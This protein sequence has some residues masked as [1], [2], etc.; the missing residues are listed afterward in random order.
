MK[1]VGIIP[2]RME[3]KRLPGKP[4][5]KIGGKSMIQR[6]YEASIKCN[7]LNDVYVASDNDEIINHV[8]LFGN[9]IKTSSKPINGTE[10]VYEAYLK[11]QKKYDFI[12]NIQGDEPFINSN[13]INDL[14]Q[15]CNKKNEICTLIKEHKY[16]DELNKNSVIKVVMNKDY[17][18]MYFSR[19]LIPNNNKNTLYNTHIGIYGYK[20]S[21]LSKLVELKPSSLEIAESLEQLRWMENNFKIKVAKTNHDSFGIDTKNDWKVANEIVKT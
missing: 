9:F 12:I 15:I 20:P 4:L 16:S 3:S 1:I 19:S 7:N 10:R 14:I 21:V 5:L 13:Q 6:V 11:L 18:A 17:E 2:S 8:K